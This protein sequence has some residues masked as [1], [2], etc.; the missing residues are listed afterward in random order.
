M[1]ESL[2]SFSTNYFR[3]NTHG[4]LNV[5]AAL[6]DISVGLIV[7]LQNPRSRTNNSFFIVTVNTFVWLGCFGMESLVRDKSS[8]FLWQSL[9]YSFG[10]PFISV[11]FYYLSSNLVDGKNQ[12]FVIGLG[13]IWAVLAMIPMTFFT[14]SVIGIDD[15]SW[16]RFPYFKNDSLGFSYA[17]FLL[18]PFMLLALFTFVEFYRGW[19]KAISPRER[20]QMKNIL[21]GFLIAYTGAFDFIGAFK[22]PFYPFGYISLTLFQGI[23]AYT[24]IRHQFLEINILL[25]KFS[26]IFLTYSFILA[27]LIPLIISI[28]KTNFESIL[29]QQ[30]IAILKIGLLIGLGISIGPLIYATILRRIFWLKNQSSTGLTHELKSP[31]ATIQS[32]SQVLLDHN[33]Q[34]IPDKSKV[35]DY[36]HMIQRNAER[37]EIFVQD[38]LKIAQIQNDEIS[39]QKSSIDLTKTIRELASTYHHLA[40]KKGVSFNFKLEPAS[41][42]EVDP[43]KIQQVISNLISNA[44]RFS[45]SGSIVISTMQKGTSLC[46]SIADTGQG[47]PKA[48]LN[49]VFD[50]FFHGKNSSNGSGLGLSIAKA[51][52]EA[53]GGKIW[54]E[55][56][57]DGKGTTVTFTLPT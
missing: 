25:R 13:L 49:R 6:F 34:E 16:G 8:A 12:K 42:V 29:P 50:R 1:I 46:C 57:G 10:V 27:L 45:N 21:I 38:L 40:E 37:L 33:N 44:L 19:K 35:F 7:L 14:R 28:V 9:S 4:L 43:G 47:I 15:Y 54:A 39:L 55:S 26:V 56:E 48:D 23:V 24:I 41:I 32:A 36:L 22:I 18:G 31:L 11:S 20:A 17:L 3:Y 30:S 2:F 5:A 51:W 53:H 52:V